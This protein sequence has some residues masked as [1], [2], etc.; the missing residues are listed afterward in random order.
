MEMLGQLQERADNYQHDNQPINEDFQAVKDA[1]KTSL[2]VNLTHKNWINSLSYL[3]HRI[4]NS[5]PRI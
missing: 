2:Q 1:I 4:I 5:F 3:S